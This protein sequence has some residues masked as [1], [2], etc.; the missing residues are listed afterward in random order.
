MIIVATNPVADRLPGTDARKVGGH[1]SGLGKNGARTSTNESS[2][3]RKT[4]LSSLRLVYV[5]VI[6]SFRC[7]KKRLNGFAAMSS[8]RRIV[9]AILIVSLG[10]AAT[11]PCASCSSTRTFTEAKSFGCDACP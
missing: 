1:R 2:R 3:A 7:R 4:Y 9:F 6:R 8:I 11:A 5:Q 10:F